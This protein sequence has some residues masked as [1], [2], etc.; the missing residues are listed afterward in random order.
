MIFTRKRN[1]KSLEHIKNK[2]RV[3]EG[4]WELDLFGSFIS[5]SSRTTLPKKFRVYKESIN[6][7]L[8][9]RKQKFV[10]QNFC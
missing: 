10:R 8:C 7:H 9:V 1:M 6:E 5:K 3:L 2:D 4:D